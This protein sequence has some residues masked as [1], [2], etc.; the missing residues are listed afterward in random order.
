M[1]NIAANLPRGYQ[2]LHNFQHDDGLRASLN[3]LARQTFHVEFENWYQAGYWRERCTPFACIHAGEVAAALLTHRLD[4]VWDGRQMQAIQIGTVMTHP[5][6]RGRGLA[7]ELLSA[8]VELPGADF[9]FLFANRDVLDFYPRFGFHPV[10][11]CRFWVDWPEQSSNASASA[12][13][14]PR[15][16]LE[17]LQELARER[18][19]VSDVLGISGDQHLL[20]FYGQS[21]FSN[22]L[23]DLGDCIIIYQVEGHTLNLYDVVSPHPIDLDALLPRIVPPGVRRVE[24]HFTP[25]MRGL[26]VQAAPLDDPDST[27]FLRPAFAISGPFRFPATAQA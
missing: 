9:F 10:Q 17:R 18:V 6:H 14:P 22:S 4:V 16:S 11:E 15:A 7:R 27:L 12:S 24:F 2:I 23:Y 25:H 3:N 19:P 8:A 26:P 5:N 21:A 13:A 1:V 20:M